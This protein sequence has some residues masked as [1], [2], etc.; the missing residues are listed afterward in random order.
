MEFWTGEE[1]RTRPRQADRPLTL[2]ECAD[3]LG[4]SDEW[5][6]QAILVGVVTADGAQVKLQTETLALNGRRAYRIHESHF[7]TFLRAIGWAHL[8]ARP[9]HGPEL[10]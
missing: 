4:Y 3:Y 6:R 5:V 9:P 8:P 10:S 7:Y 2:R 1:R